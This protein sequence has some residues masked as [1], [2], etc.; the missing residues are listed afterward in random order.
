MF[1]IVHL[2]LMARA[3]QVVILGLSQLTFVRGVYRV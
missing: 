1:V 3:A 2:T